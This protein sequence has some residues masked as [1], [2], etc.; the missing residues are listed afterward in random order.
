MSGRGE[1]CGAGWG[2]GERCGHLVEGRHVS[3][4]TSWK[5]RYFSSHAC[6][7][8]REDRT[9]CLS[10]PDSSH[11]CYHWPRDAKTSASSLPAHLGTEM[12]L[13]NHVLR[14]VG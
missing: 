10:P 2:R 11:Y 3:K 7:P 6:S 5:D 4:L 12:L 8:R 9:N 14:G 1:I 13:S